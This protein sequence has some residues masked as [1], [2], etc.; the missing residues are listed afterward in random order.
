MIQKWQGNL[1]AAAREIGMARQNLRNRL[2]SLGF[3]VEGLRMGALVLDQSKRTG[4]H[5]SSRSVSGGTVRSEDVACRQDRG[6]ESAGVIC[7]SIA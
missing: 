7:Q 2:K 4:T 3:D 1:T 5:L 6:S